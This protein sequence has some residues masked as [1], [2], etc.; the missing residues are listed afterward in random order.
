MLKFEVFRAATIVQD[1]SPIRNYDNPDFVNETDLNN[2]NK[3]YPIIPFVYVMS[4]C[5][6]Q[7]LLHNGVF[8]GNKLNILNDNCLGC[9]V[10]LFFAS[11]NNLHNTSMV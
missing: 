9:S 3:T 7:L 11:N 5:N 4:L 1:F 10:E 6:V 2:K 8:V